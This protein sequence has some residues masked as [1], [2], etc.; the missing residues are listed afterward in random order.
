MVTKLP[1][2]NLLQYFEALI[3]YV[4]DRSNDDKCSIPVTSINRCGVWYNIL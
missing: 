4:S 2:D 1:E 3:T